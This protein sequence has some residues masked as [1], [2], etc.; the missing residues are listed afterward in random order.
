MNF[1]PRT[2][3]LWTFFLILDFLIAASIAEVWIRAFIPVAN[4]CYYHDPILGDMFC[5]N[6]K[7]YGYVQK[8]YSNIF[9]TNSKGFHDIE[10]HKRK[11]EN[12]LRIHI[13]G[14]SIIAGAGVPINKTIPS[15]LESY[16]NE[17]KPAIP[18]EVLN[19]ATAEDST[20]AEFTAYKIVG[21]EFS[22]D[23]VICYFMNDFDDNIFETHQ[24]TRSPYYAVNSEGEL[25]F[26]PP[27]PVDLTTPWEQFK[28]SSRL[29]RL[30]ANKLLSSKLYHDI[31]QQL[32][33]M[34]YYFH[35]DLPSH[36]KSENS[37][38]EYRKKNL[39]QKAWSITLRI[40]QEF[41]AAVEKDG[42]T[43]ILVDGTLI[44]KQ[45]RGGH[46][47]KDL[48]TF[49]D[50]NSIQYIP[51]Y[52]E[53]VRLKKDKNKAKYFLEDGHPTVLGNKILSQFLA[54]KLMEQF[55]SGKLW[56]KTHAESQKRKNN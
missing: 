40:L 13:Y 24:R 2:I 21:K 50:K 17:S 36:N 55:L 35:G 22:P 16:I 45:Q 51:V 14:D 47:N 31:N 33:K 34:K 52:D 5:P 9:E 6:Q 53:Y 11:K 25:I 3:L 18:V 38:T 44:K 10:R 29:Y 39:A 27:I 12:T 7:T 41:K 56:L 49:C 48:Q 8:G 1:A 20:C 43:F 32:N 46:T 30:L 28:R 15:L 23:I 37:F 19:M 4:I 26:I 54:Q 42:A